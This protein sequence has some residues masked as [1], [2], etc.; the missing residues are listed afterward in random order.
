[1]ALPTWI[2]DA[3]RSEAAPLKRTF[4]RCVEAQHVVSTLRLVDDLDD[5]AL[6]EDILEDTKPPVPT[7]CEGLHWLYMTPFRYG[8]YPTGS[9]FRRAGHSEGVYYVSEQTDTAVI[10]TA[11]H[12]LLF[13]ADSPETPFPRQPTEHTCFDVPID[14]GRAVDLTR[15]PFLNAEHLWTHPTDYAPTQD[16]EGEAR[17]NDVDLI[18]Y[19]SVRDPSRKANAALLSC[20]GFGA[21]QPSRQ[22]TW[23]LW[24]N[25]TG[26]HA[27]CEFN[28]ER[29]SLPT[30]VFAVDDRF[31]NFNWLRAQ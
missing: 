12:L 28:R 20:T 27:I 16:L 5:Q 14:A 30:D 7:A 9:R 18:R 31:A 4:W 13:Y 23:R 8:L 6:L 19:A 15:A 24:F 17:E 2:P 10:E 11:F 3:L 29:F 25:K 21:Q 26:I 1:M 22:R